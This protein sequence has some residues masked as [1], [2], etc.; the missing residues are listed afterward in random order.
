MKLTREEA[1]KIIEKATD[2]DDGA[3]ENATEEYFNEETGEMPT[4]YDVLAPLGV[5]MAEYDA[6]STG[7]KSIK[8]LAICLHCRSMFDSSGLK[9]EDGCPNC[10]ERMDIW[11]SSEGVIDAFDGEGS[12]ADS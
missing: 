10:G 1:L 11:T 3:W 12:H 2:Q 5:S 6:A 7:D 8:A 4:I 9:L